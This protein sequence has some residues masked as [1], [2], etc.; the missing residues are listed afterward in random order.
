MIDVNEHRSLHVRY[1]AVSTT[2]SQSTIKI[3]SGSPSLAPGIV[4]LHF[5]IVGMR[6]TPDITS[7]EHVSAYNSTTYSRE[8]HVLGAVF[9]APNLQ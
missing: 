3:E 4:L 6:L 8:Y 1:R 9:L 2:S 5:A 7:F